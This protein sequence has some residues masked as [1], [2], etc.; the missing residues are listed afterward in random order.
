M[1]CVRMLQ[2]N[3]RGTTILLT[4]A[5]EQKLLLISSNNYSNYLIF[6]R[7]S[8]IIHCKNELHVVEINI[9]SSPEIHMYTVV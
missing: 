9:S 8:V 3:I 4:G 7:R 5:N 6:A 1:T 2:R